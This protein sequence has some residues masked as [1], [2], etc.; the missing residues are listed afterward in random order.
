[1]A[2]LDVEEA[3]TERA[4]EVIPLE[5]LL[6][7]I[8]MKNVRTIRQFAHGIFSRE[9]RQ[10]DGAHLLLLR[11]IVAPPQL[12]VSSHQQ[13]SAVEFR[14]RCEAENTKDAKNRFLETKQRDP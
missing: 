8:E 10:T 4:S 9:F 1:M 14:Q 6:D 2:I 11:S 13:S 3:P 12:T 5:P 7:A